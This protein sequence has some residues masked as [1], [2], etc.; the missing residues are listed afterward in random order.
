M[1]SVLLGQRDLL[2]DVARS[3][4]AHR[5]PYLLSGSFASSYYGFPR[6]THDID[7]VVEVGTKQ[8]KQLAGTLRG[9][10]K[11]FALTARTLP[12]ITSPQM[13]NTFHSGTSTKVDFWITNT[14]DFSLKYKR[15]R[16][17]T[18]GR[19][20]VSVIAPEDLILTKLAWCKELRS[21]RH[22]GDCVGIWRVQKGKLDEAYVLRR[23]GELSVTA[24]LKEIASQ[25]FQET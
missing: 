17:V 14:D 1:K 18:I 20:R 10:G 22:M 12:T 15:R 8:L 25:Q 19:T 16:S 11:D 6:A 7:F 2:V 24:L 4:N 21:E 23:A 5:V 13:V 3:L 9:L